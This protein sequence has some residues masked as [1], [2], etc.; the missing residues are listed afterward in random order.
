MGHRL[1]A[2]GGA[3]AVTIA[4]AVPVDAQIAVPRR[5]GGGWGQSSND[6]YRTG[7][8]FGLR[9]GERD[10]RDGKDYGYRR[11][12]AYEDADRGFPG[13]GS[14]DAYRRDFRRG[15]EDGY[16]VAYRRF[17]G[18]GRS[19]GY[20]PGYGYPD[21]RRGGTYG[22]PGGYGNRGGYGYPGG[23][24][25]G[26]YGF[27]T[28]YSDGYEAGLNDGRRNRAFDP[29]GEGRYRSA[30]RGYDSRYGSRDAYRY[31]YRNGFRQGYE[32]GYRNSRRYDSRRGWPF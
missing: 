7:Y 31:E 26:R 9:E 4:L 30:N 21:S 29:T 19:G 28:G 12:D 22:Y 11:D 27:E 1:L 23:S 24:R 8:N 5:P 18:Y 20:Y 16:A 32:E 25:G 10:A 2:L 14:R 17:G 6:G 3:L 15:Y 13:Y